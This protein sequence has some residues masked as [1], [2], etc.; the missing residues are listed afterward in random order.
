MILVALGERMDVAVV[1]VAVFLI[2]VL[3]IVMVAP[4]EVEVVADLPIFSVKF[5]LNMAT[6]QM[7]VA[8]SL[9]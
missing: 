3:D 5:A 8:S 7:F 9:I 1:V 6:L 4:E 2:V